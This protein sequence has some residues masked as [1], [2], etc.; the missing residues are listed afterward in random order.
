MKVVILAGGYGSRLSEETQKIPKPLVEINGFPLIYYIMKIYS[1]YGFN[2]FII[3][4]G[5][6]GHL[7]KEYFY[8]KLI[9]DGDVA[10]DFKTQS[11]INLKSKQETW[12]V[13]LIDTGIDTLTS[14]RL[15]KVKDYIKEKNFMLS[16]G[17]GVADI[18]IKNLLN[19]HLKHKK[20]ATLTAINFP[21]RFGAL[22]LEKDRIIKFEEKVPSRINGGFFVF[23]KEI[24]KYLDNEMLE[25]NTLPNLAK[26]GQ[27][28]AYYHNG[29]WQCVDTLRDKEYL[30]KVLKENKIKLY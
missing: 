13:A 5:Y 19:F 15:Y 23:N 14:E 21:S 27:L 9:Y 18:N 8:K 10:F 3:C 16:Y 4:L 25:I 22:I 30:E 26:Q 17:D 6:K 1:S 11:I 29:F 24:F 28:M 7:I 12:K 20:I 2:D